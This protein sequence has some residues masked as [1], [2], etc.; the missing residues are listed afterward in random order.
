MPQV[1][2]PTDLLPPWERIVEVL[3]KGDEA[4]AL[5]A[6]IVTFIRHELKRLPS[7]EKFEHLME[8]RMEIESDKDG[9]ANQEMASA[10]DKVRERKKKL[11]NFDF[12]KP[13]KKD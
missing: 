6:A 12:G 4:K 3:Y 9:Y 5:D 2:I 11:E 1:K 13:K 8:K 10:M 7:G